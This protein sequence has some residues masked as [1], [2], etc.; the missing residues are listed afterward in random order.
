M[1]GGHDLVLFRRS[2]A[3]KSRRSVLVRQEAQERAGR[4]G[5]LLGDGLAQDF[6]QR[7]KFE[8]FVFQERSTTRSFSSA[9]TVQVA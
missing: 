2:T 1:I 8:R 6:L 9:R 3:A 7:H 4:V 5:D